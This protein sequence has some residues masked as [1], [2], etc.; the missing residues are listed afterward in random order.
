[1]SPFLKDRLIANRTIFLFFIYVSSGIV[2]PRIRLKNLLLVTN[3]PK[4]AKNNPYLILHF[5]LYWNFNKPK[6][7]TD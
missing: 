2:V 5:L 1:M 6:K 3:F 7:H 4:I